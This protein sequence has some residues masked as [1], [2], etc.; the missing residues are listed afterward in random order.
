MGSD[1]VLEGQEIFPAKGVATKLPTRA[2]VLRGAQGFAD[3]GGLNVVVW[4][5]TTLKIAWA[6]ATTSDEWYV[7]DFNRMVVF[8]CVRL[9]CR[10]AYQSGSSR[11]L[12]F[13]RLCRGKKLL[14]CVDLHPD[15]ARRARRTSPTRPVTSAG[16]RSF[17]IG[18]CLHEC[19]DSFRDTETIPCILESQGRP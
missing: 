18:I 15:P 17:L 16:S 8:H 7:S 4:M 10:I 19:R 3:E 1:K 13:T 5:V 12:P 14:P 6:P 9:P 2:M 11:A